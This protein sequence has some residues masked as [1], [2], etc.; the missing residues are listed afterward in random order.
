MGSRSRGRI[1]FG[2]L[3]TSVP[4]LP[5][6]SPDNGSGESPEVA[7]W[8]V[9]ARVVVSLAVVFHLVAIVAGA[10]GVPPSSLLERTVADPFTP[11][12]DLVDLGYSYRYYAEPP[13]TPV[14]TATLSF[15]EGRPDETVR[16]PGREVAGPRMRHQRQLAL[17]NAL[18]NDLQEVKARTGRAAGAGWAGLRPSS[19][20]DADGLPKCH[21][22]Y[23][24]AFDSGPGSSPCSDLG[25][26]LVPIRPVRGRPVHH[27]GMDRRFPVRRILKD[28]AVYLSEL[29]RA[30]R[31]GWN[32]FLFTPADPTAVGLI[33]VAVGLLAFWSLLVFGLD[34]SDYFGSD[35]WASPD[36]I[37]MAQRP[38]AWSFWFLVPDGWLRAVWCLC[39]GVM[40]LYALGL[41]SRVTVILGWVIVVSTVRRVPIA[42]Y[43]F[44]QVL[45]TLAL[46]LAVTGASGQAVSL[47]RFWRRWRQARASARKPAKLASSAGRMVA[48]D[49]PGVPTATISANLTLRLIQ[50]HMVLIYGLAGLAKLQGPSWWNGTALWGTMTAGEF[51]VLDFTAM[52]AWPRLINLLTHTSLGSNCCILC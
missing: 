16:L 30:A 49:E 4:S 2:T 46:Y 40:A 15:G 31:S 43:G 10:L 41:F 51:V 23:P 6:S 44:D 3:A 26:R 36:A 24:P 38:L 50:L 11:Y 42:L 1:A 17:A 52:A 48:P 47:D 29:A 35:G 7:G 9:W 19:L 18:F 33:R 32:A 28:L 21:I 27:A 25:A 39:L 13:P 14:V 8:P 37:R 34:L 12:F 20:S 22:A 5:L 45:S